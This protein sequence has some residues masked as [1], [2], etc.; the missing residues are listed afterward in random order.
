MELSDDLKSKSATDLEEWLLK[1]LE[2]DELPFI[3]M[4]AAL[5]ALTENGHTD[6]ARSCA[7][8]LQ[9]ALG[10]RAAKTETLLL[11]RFRQTLAEGEEEFMAQCRVAL[12]AAFKDRLGSAYI[13]NAGFAGALTANEC[14][15]AWR[16]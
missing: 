4:M 15:R 1:S 16:S 3:E 14:L 11:L 13:K 9:D 5:R 2:S 10:E 12:G 8:F 6:E 7:E